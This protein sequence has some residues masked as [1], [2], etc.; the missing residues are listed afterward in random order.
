MPRHH[1]RLPKMSRPNLPPHEAHALLEWQIAMGAD[2][3]ID[4]VAR[5]RLSPAPA[6]VSTDQPLVGAVPVPLPI[7]IVPDPPP[8]AGEGRVGVS[9]PRSTE[10]KA[11][12][13]A[14]RPG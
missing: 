10:G 5:N 3:A 12:I 4:N 8:L 7:S 2:E 6:V 14:T 9:P 11:E 13:A 1:D